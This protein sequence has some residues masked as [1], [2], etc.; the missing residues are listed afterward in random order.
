MHIHRRRF[1]LSLTALLLSPLASAVEPQPSRLVFHVNDGRREHQESVLRNLQNHLA[2]VG[3]QGLDLRVMLQG[4][5]ITLL[6]LPEALAHTQGLSRANA[7]KAFRQ[8]IDALRAQGVIFEVSAESLERHHIDFRSDLYGVE[9]RNVVPNAL[10]HLAEL[11][12]H[13]YTYIK[14]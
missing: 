10:A 5:G 2:S 12:Q 1:L 11:Q 3:S 8:R 14:P 13:G 9:P 7:T 6:L 4:A